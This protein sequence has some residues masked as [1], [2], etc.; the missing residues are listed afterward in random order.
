LR[1][2]RAIQEAAQAKGDPL[3]KASKTVQVL[4]A[5]DD[6]V[7]RAGICTILEEAPDIK[8]V[9]EAKNGAGQNGW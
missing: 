1:P 9:G 3:S 2:I 8:V 7:T 6:L 5:D 4:V